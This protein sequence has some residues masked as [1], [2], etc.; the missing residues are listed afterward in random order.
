MPKKKPQTGKP[1][2]NKD[3]KGYEIEI[4]EFGEI[5]SNFGVEKLNDFLN[6]NVTDKKLKDRDDLTDIIKK[7]DD[8]IKNNNNQSIKNDE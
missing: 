6:K 4:N 8:P 7:T 5:I 2:V 3:L 1:Q